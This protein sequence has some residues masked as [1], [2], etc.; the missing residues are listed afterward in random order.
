MPEDEPYGAFSH[1]YAAPMTNSD[2]IFPTVEHYMMYQKAKLFK[3]LPIM[4]TI[5]SCSSPE[6]A[7]VAGRKVHNFDSQSWKEHREQIVYEG[8]WLKFS[9]HPH[10]ADMLL[11]TGNRP[12]IEA[13]PED[14]LWGIGFSADKAASNRENW[15]QNLCGKAIERVR[16]ALCKA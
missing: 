12:L 3:D 2:G 8:N 6:E 4:N 10:L 15:G 1:W 5:L 13:S 16:A 14:S 11:E 9:Q 7:K